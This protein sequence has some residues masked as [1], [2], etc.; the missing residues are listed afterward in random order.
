MTAGTCPS[1]GDPLGTNPACGKCE[2][3]A[4]LVAFEWLEAGDNRRIESEVD[5]GQQR[6]ARI[7]GH[8]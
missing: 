3:H 7:L 2:D 8:R 6:A 4:Y 1:C 5:S